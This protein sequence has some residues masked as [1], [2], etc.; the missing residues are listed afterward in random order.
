MF[1]DEIRAK[2]F[3]IMTFPGGCNSKLNPILFGLGDKFKVNIYLR[4]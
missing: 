1:K 3:E 4:L 2:N